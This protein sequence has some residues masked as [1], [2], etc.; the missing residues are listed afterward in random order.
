MGNFTTEAIIIYIT[1]M[2]WRTCRFQQLLLIIVA[3]T[4]L[5]ENRRQPWA[6]LT[7]VHAGN[8][9]PQGVERVVMFVFVDNMNND[10]S[11]AFPYFTA[12]K[13]FPAMFASSDA[14]F[15]S[16]VPA[17]NSSYRRLMSSLMSFSVFMLL[18][19]VYITALQFNSYKHIFHQI[20]KIGR[21]L[22]I[23]LAFMV[24]VAP[25]VLILRVIFGLK[26]K[27]LFILMILRLVLL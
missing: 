6:I 26:E 21:K 14:V 5:V 11:V 1:G 16:Q 3:V 24:L 19:L 27:G 20:N 23:L 15:S 25:L 18:A 13:N 10:G 8:R 12:F 4:F 17:C 9:V 2:E 7:D 22:F